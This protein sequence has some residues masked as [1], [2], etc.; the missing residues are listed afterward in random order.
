MGDKYSSY[1]QSPASY[2]ESPAEGDEITTLPTAEENPYYPIAGPVGAISLVHG[3]SLSALQY[4]QDREEWETEPNLDDNG[5]V[6]EDVV[7]G[8]G[9][10]GKDVIDGVENGVN[11]RTNDATGGKAENTNGTGGNA[12]N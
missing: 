1:T 12:G 2:P 3:N 4:E 8:V 7:D 9:D 5:N 10:A 6:I 11:D